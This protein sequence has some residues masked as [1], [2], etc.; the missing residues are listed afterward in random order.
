MW[1]LR[2]VGSLEAINDL[3]L[4]SEGLYLEKNNKGIFRV[5]KLSKKIYNNILKGKEDP[6][7]YNV[8]SKN[9]VRP[10]VKYNGGDKNEE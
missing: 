1:I 6:S 2:N 8:F 3:L 5:N 10:R 4:T 7:I 9:Y